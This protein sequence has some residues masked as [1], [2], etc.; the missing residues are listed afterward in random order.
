M[1]HTKNILQ[2]CGNLSSASFL[3]S[4]E[5]LLEEG[6]AQCGDSIVMMTMGPGSTIECCLGEF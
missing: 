6:I 4:H 2:N 1:R 3:F 5:R